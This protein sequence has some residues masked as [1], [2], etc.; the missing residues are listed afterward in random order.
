MDNEKQGQPI[1]QRNTLF[2]ASAQL[3]TTPLVPESRAVY[4]PPQL[5]R[6]SS[7]RHESGGIPGVSEVSVF[8]KTAGS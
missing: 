2:N 8:S 7:S 6:L 5:L 3:P 1:L 4:R